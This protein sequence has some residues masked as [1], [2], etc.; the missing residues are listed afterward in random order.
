MEFAVQQVAAP[1]WGG[2]HLSL[3]TTEM[4]E[5]SFGNRGFF[6]GRGELT[7]YLEPPVTAVRA[8]IQI[9]RLQINR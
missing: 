6:G 7:D 9:V 5:A 3:D 2:F 1:A 8:T 4:A